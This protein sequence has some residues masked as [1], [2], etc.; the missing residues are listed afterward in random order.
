[1]RKES[2]KLV[3][4]SGETINKIDAESLSEAISVFAKIKRLEDIELLK[5]YSVLKIK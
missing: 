5:I 4:Q 2:Y 3:N 1:M